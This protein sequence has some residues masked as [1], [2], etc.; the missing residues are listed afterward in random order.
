MNMEF[1]RKMPT[2]QAIKEMYPISDT[3]AAQKKE[4]DQALE[5]VF[6]G[7][8]DRLILIIGP[9][10]ADREDAVLDYIA[11]L[12]EVQERVKDKIVIIPRA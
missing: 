8:D 10:S 5:A 2:P 4:T 3:L 11:R 12:R 9:C 1:K 7:A 6:T